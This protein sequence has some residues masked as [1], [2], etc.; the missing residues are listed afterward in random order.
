M[1]PFAATSILHQ[2]P[3]VIQDGPPALG[4]ALRINLTSATGGIGD[5]EQTQDILD[6]GPTSQAISMTKKIR[7]P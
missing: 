5:G 3:D 4:R 6:A 7:E 1:R 2:D